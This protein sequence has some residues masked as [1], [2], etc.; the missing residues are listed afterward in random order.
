MLLLPCHKACV[1][2]C[3]G[4]LLISKKSFDALGLVIGS[5]ARSEDSSTA[6]HACIQ[7]TDLSP[8]LA[9]SST[10]ANV[11]TANVRRRSDFYAR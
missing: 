1:V 11:N 7:E 9:Q 3:S 10:M 4:E 8:L 2:I 6:D 5:S